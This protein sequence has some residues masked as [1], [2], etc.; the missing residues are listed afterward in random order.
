M[1]SLII[2]SVIT[3]GAFIFLCYLFNESRIETDSVTIAAVEARSESASMRKA[4]KSP[5]PRV[6]EKRPEPAPAGRMD[7]EPVEPALPMMAAAGYEYRELLEER[8]ENYVIPQWMVNFFSSSDV[9]HSLDSADK[10]VFIVK[11]S[12]PNNAREGAIDIS[13]ECDMSAQTVSLKF[14]LGEGAA[15]EQLKT[16]FYL[17]ERGDLFELNRLVRQQE[18]RIDVLTRSADYTLEYVATRRI[19]LPQHAL[20]QLKNVLSKIPA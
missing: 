16:K 6:E 3:I 10:V 12:D 17:F 13:A 14:S 1:I 15:A 11:L 18:A 7:A 9:C 2:L 20:A 8:G 4:G 19:R 5:S